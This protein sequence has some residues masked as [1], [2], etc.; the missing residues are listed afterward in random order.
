MALVVA[1]NKKIKEIITILFTSVVIL[2]CCSR[3]D[4]I[5]VY[6]KSTA[7][8]PPSLTHLT[9]CFVATPLSSSLRSNS[10]NQSQRLIGWALYQFACRSRWRDDSGIFSKFTE[11][12]ACYS[13]FLQRLRFY[14]LPLFSCRPKEAF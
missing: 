9:K 12:A 2:P 5:E 13:C 7:R 11:L 6:K 8:E 10:T 3:E 1:L 4:R 14:S